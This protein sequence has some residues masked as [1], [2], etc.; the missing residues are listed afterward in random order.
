MGV[1]AERVLPNGRPSG[2]RA[3]LEDCEGRGVKF[4]GAILRSSSFDR[5]DLANADFQRA[6]LR[7]ASFQDRPWWVPRSIVP[8]F[9]ATR[10][11]R[12]TSPSRAPF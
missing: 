11:A 12:I 10:I 3:M 1:I 6:D 4:T 7:R 2:K 8:T 5:A 9:A